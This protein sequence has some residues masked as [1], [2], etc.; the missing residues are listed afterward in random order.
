MKRTL[1]VL[2]RWLVKYWP[3]LC[4][5]FVAGYQKC[6]AEMHLAMGT[7]T[8]IS[9]NNIWISLTLCGWEKIQN[10]WKLV[11]PVIGS[12]TSLNMYALQS[13]HPTVQRNHETIKMTVTF[14]S[15]ISVCIFLITAVFDST[16]NVSTSSHLKMTNARR[17]RIS[18]FQNPKSFF[19]IYNWCHVFLT[20]Y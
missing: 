10:K 9:V 18:M 8:Q 14:M 17:L 12:L 13:F 2:L 16:F 19:F 11:H 1:P 5:K 7:F 3:E 6:L 20:V 4:L 15:I